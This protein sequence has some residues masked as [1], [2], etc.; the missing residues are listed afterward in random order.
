MEAA[1]TTVQDVPPKHDRTQA[2]AHITS[3]RSCSVETQGGE[4]PEARTPEQAC[5]DGHEKDRFG[6]TGPNWTMKKNG[7][8]SDVVYCVGVPDGI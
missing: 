5:E 6:L 8:F 2:M 3:T 4:S 7:D 1:G